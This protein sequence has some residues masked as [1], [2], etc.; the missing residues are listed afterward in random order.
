VGISAKAVKN[1]KAN[2]L[3]AELIIYLKD[4]NVVSPSPDGESID[5]TA[6]IQGFCVDIDSDYIYLGLPTGE[7]TRTIGHEVAAMIELAMPDEQFL[8]L[9]FPLNDD[10]VH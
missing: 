4:M 1:L 8:D 3:N 2:F 5:V 6:M 10:E 9:D 7:I